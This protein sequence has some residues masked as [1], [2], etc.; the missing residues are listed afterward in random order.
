M[1]RDVDIRDVS[2]RSFLVVRSEKDDVCIVPSTDVMVK[3][4][5]PF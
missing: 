3:V 5:S 2:I 4:M 1:I